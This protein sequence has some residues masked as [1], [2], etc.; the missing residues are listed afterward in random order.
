MW[1]RGGTYTSMLLGFPLGAAVVVVFWV[2]GRKFPGSVALRNAHPV[3]LFTGGLVFAPWN[4]SYVWPAVPV[5]AFSWLYVK[6][7]HLALWSKYN[8]VLAAAFSTGIA[9]SALVQFFALSL[10][11]VEVKWWG[12]SVVKE[13]CEGTACVRL[14]LA[15]GEIFGPAPGTFN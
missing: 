3:L 4:L 1:G 13:G 9:L 14:T 10:H 6:V 5:A 8:Y 2:L 12:N 7:R 11:G 15:E